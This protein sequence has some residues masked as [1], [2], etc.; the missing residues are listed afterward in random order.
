MTTI[1]YSHRDL[2]DGPYVTALATVGPDGQPQV[3]PVWCNR[4]GNCVLINTMKL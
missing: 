2:I 1:P 3:T 4:C